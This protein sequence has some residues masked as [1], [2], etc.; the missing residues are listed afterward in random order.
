[1]R[2]YTGDLNL[3]IFNETRTNKS[4]TFPLVR[5]V[6][7]NWDVAYKNQAY[8]IISALGVGNNISAAVCYGYVVLEFAIY[9][10]LP[11]AF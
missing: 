11:Y 9:A 4:C 6:H 7:G 2:I 3:H 8:R 10:N 1:M 5:S